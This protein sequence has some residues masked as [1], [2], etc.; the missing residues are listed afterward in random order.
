M[1][2]V[3]LLRS[4]LFVNPRVSLN[5]I[6]NLRAGKQ[7]STGETG[8]A[9]VDF[10]GIQGKVIVDR[11]HIYSVHVKIDDFVAYDFQRQFNITFPLQLELEYTLLL[12]QLRDEK[13]SS[14]FGVKALYRELDAGSGGFDPENPDFPVSG[15]GVFENG[16]NQHMFEV[17]T[18][19]KYSF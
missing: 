2:K 11:K 3:Y 16:A 19:Y 7:Q 8:K 14:K 9:A 6:V 4:N 1:R 18:Y 5:Y 13:L 12:D 10:F 17:R 15:G